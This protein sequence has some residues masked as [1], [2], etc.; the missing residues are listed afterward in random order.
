MQRGHDHPA[1]NL[2]VAA[3]RHHPA[4]IND[5]LTRRM[6]DVGEVHILSLGGLVVQND[7]NLLLVFHGESPWLAA[8]RA[9]WS[10]F[11]AG[12]LSI[13]LLRPKGTLCLSWKLRASRPEILAESHRR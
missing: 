3:P 5:E 4:Q 11:Y 2:D 1:V 10:A 13:C 8:R 6:D 7:T 9:R 12:A